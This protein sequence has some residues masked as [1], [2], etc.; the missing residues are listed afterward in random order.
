MNFLK[1]PVFASLIVLLMTVQGALA[2]QHPSFLQFASPISQ[3]TISQS[4]VS[5]PG[6]QSTDTITVSIT[7]SAIYRY[8]N[9]SYNGQN[10]V[11]R[12]L[13]AGQPSSC[14]VHPDDAG[15]TWLT[16]TCTLTV[17]I[18]AANFSFSTPGTSKLRNYITAYSCTENVLDLG[19]VRFRLGWDCHGNTTMPGMWQIWNFTA[20][21]AQTCGNGTCDSG[22]SC[23]SC[24]ADCGACQT[25]G[26]SA[27]EG[28]EQCDCGTDMACNST[29]LGGATC[30]SRM[31][32]GYTGTLNCT[33]SCTFNT[34]ACVAPCTPY[35]CIGLGY[36]CGNLSDGCGG[37]LACGNCSIDQNCTNGQCVASNSSFKYIVQNG[38]GYAD[39]IVSSSATNMVKLA[40][41]YFQMYIKNMTGVTLPISNTIN[42]SKQYHV[43]IG[44]SSYTDNLEIN[45]VGCH[46]GGFKMVSGSNYLALLGD[47]ALF[48][49]SGP[50]TMSQWDALTGDTWGNDF[51]NY[52]LGSNHNS[53]YNIGR[54]D[55]RGSMNAV[56]EFLYNQGI[57]WY[58]PS[59]IGTVI[60]AKSSVG[61][62]NVNSL[63]NPQFS[64]RHFYIMYKEFDLLEPYLYPNDYASQMQWQLSLRSNSYYEYMVGAD[65]GPGHGI[66][67]VIERPETRAEH[68]EYYAVLGGVR[69]NGVPDLCSAGLV[70]ENIRYAKAMFD[71]YNVSIVSVM[72]S[73]GFVGQMSENA[74]ASCRAM[75]IPGRNWESDLS[76]YVWD[77]VNNV[78]WGI[79]NDSRYAGKKIL[80]AAYPPYLLPPT[81]LSRPVA[82]NLVVMLTRWRSN[83]AEPAY[84]AKYVD[85]TNQ[86]ENWIASGSGEIYSYDY[87]LYNSPWSDGTQNVPAFF[88]HI[89]FSD[90]KNLKEHNSKGEFIEIYSQWPLDS[91][92]TWEYP[93]AATS[94]NV[95]MTARAY[96]DADQDVDAL[97]EEYYTL[98]YGP[99][100][101]QMKAFVEYSESHY[102]PSAAEIQTMRQ[103]LTNARAT[104]GNT[105]YGQ[106]IDSL[107]GLIN[108]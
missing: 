27:I 42:T 31:G 58:S 82:P 29:E 22:E 84:N 107:I 30:A 24:P 64:M 70:A 5:F 96:W 14:T 104:A 15:G 39:I 79:Y 105:V 91:P 21:L 100:S 3:F 35:T 98:Y 95:Y 38:V 2:S 44:Q 80:N 28:T 88:P 92:T 90:L 18:S 26:N 99:A 78:S 73:D 10:W 72:P 32:A 63:I 36:I 37:T 40:G 13:L 60:P 25:C 53:E 1:L 50:T 16:G 97:L 102:N 51:I 75:I 106:R 71:L 34:S 4:T 8:V 81:H 89:I 57:R 23:S 93:F 59:N 87:Y 56:F 77:Y 101:A 12:T 66:V 19:I 61:F 85:I 43:Y 11:Q 49:L 48:V 55:G 76:N 41:N 45:S 103:M 67:A 6:N 17:P 68:P 108:S 86:W 54:S 69:Q 94:F 46:D 20:G 74:S 52:Y 65:G 47:D 83:F 33:Q 9:T 62:G 7:D